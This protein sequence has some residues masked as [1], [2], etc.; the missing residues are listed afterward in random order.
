MSNSED[1]QVAVHL[2]QT[3]RGKL[4]EAYS[5]AYSIA[6]L[7]GVVQPEQ[8]VNAIRLDFTTFVDERGGLTY[9]KSYGTDA[10]ETANSNGHARRNGNGA[11][12]RSG[13][14]RTSPQTMI[15]E[16]LEADEEL[17]VSDLLQVLDHGGQE[18]TPGHLSVILTRM[19]QGGEIQRAGR[20]RYKLV[21]A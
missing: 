10:A 20:G 15:R 1:G 18:I 4:N 9:N 7:E 13:H 19:T 2:R 12:P 5:L 21:P 16:A 17:S 8:L 11:E 3:L 6:R 14:S